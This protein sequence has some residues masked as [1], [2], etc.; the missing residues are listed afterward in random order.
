METEPPDFLMLLGYYDRELFI[1]QGRISDFI[2]SRYAIVSQFEVHPYYLAFRKRQMFGT[3]GATV[4]VLARRKS[5]PGE[6]STG[7]P[8]PQPAQ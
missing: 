6:S 5:S 3:A 7:I 1:H 8:D 4:Y 2:A